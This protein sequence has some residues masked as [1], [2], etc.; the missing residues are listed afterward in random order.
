[1]AAQHVPDVRVVAQPVVAGVDRVDTVL[2]EVAPL[3][4]AERTERFASFAQIRL[5]FADFLEDA[6]AVDIA[7]ESVQRG[8]RNER[9]DVVEHQ[10]PDRRARLCG[11]QHADES[12]HRCTDPVDPQRLSVRGAPAAKRTEIGLRG[13]RRDPRDQRSRIGRYVE[14]R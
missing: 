1:V 14:N 7:L 9:P 6:T 10:T 11:E 3:L 5:D 13:R 8:P 4:V 2:G 12:A